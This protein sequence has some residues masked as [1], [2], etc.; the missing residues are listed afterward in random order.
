V[1][2]SFV[3]GMEGSERDR[4]LVRSV[5]DMAHDLGYRVV[6]EGIETDATFELLKQWGCDEGQ[7]Y[8][9]ARP[10]PAAEIENFMR[11]TTCAA[12]A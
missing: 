10:M 1:D 5:I 9:M 8:L 7:G 3:G 4:T 6:A 11:V 12:V 2:R